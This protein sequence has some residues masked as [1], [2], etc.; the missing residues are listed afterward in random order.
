MN[1]AFIHLV[2]D[3]NKNRRSHKTSFTNHS[4]LSFTIA[5]VTQSSNHLGNLLLEITSKLAV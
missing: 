5:T 1:K 2:Y 3:G 4:S